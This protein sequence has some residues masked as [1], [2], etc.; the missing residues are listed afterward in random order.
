LKPKELR[1]LLAAAV[2]LGAVLIVWGA[3]MMQSG[4][5]RTVQQTIQFKTFQFNGSSS[6]VSGKSYYTG[7]GPQFHLDPGDTV[8][9]TGVHPP[10]G[11]NGSLS[12]LYFAVWE[13]TPQPGSTP[14]DLIRASTLPATYTTRGNYVFFQLLSDEPLQDLAPRSSWTGDFVYLYRIPGNIGLFVTGMVALASGI[15]I[16]VLMSI[17]LMKTSKSPRVRRGQSL[18]L[19]PSHDSGAQ[20]LNRGSLQPGCQHMK[21]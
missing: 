7:G 5:E 11:F 1:I 19:K 9:V 20:E 2:V 10:A 8:E 16:V 6:V 17:T 13:S 14:D 12:N 15:T 4:T 3:Q 21:T 18:S